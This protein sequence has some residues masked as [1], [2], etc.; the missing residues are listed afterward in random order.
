MFPMYTLPISTTMVRSIK[1][2]VLA[3]VRMESPSPLRSSRGEMA[4]PPAGSSD[5]G[6]TQ[7]Q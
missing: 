5:F 2:S 4:M 7:R 1:G 3:F 6:V